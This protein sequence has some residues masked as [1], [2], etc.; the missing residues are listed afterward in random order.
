MT[1]KKRIR[2]IAIM[3]TM[4]IVLASL[5]SGVFAEN[6]DDVQQNQSEM[7]TDNKLILLSDIE[8]PELVS[9]SDVI[10]KGHVSRLPEDEEDL[11]SITFQNIDG[12][13]TTYIFS[14]PV[15]Y[16]D[17]EGIIHDKKSVLTEKIDAVAY[18]NKYGY[19]NADNDI[20]VYFP[21]SLSEDTGILLGKDNISI[22]LT[23]VASRKLETKV[24]SSKT[25]S[26][27]DE[28][29]VSLKELAAQTAE[30]I[31]K[32]IQETADDT[33]V[34]EVIDYDSVF[35]VETTLRYQ[36]TLNGFKEDIVI[37]AYDG[38]NE[39]VFNL[40][41]NG[42]R[43]AGED[44]LYYLIEP[45]TS[46]MV[47]NMGE[48]LVYSGG[49]TELSIGYDHRYDVETVTEDEEYL[50]TIIVDK[51]FLL[52]E[53]TQYPVIVDPSFEILSNNNNIMDISVR[54]NGSVI[55]NSTNN[56]VGNHY[57]EK[58][59]MRTFIKFP[60]LLNDPIFQSLAP[61]E[62]GSSYPAVKSIKLLMYSRG[63]SITTGKVT[64]YPYNTSAALD[65]TYSTTSFTTAQYNAAGDWWDIVDVPYYSQQ[66]I[67]FDITPA[68][69]EE[70]E[71]GVVLRNQY[72]GAGSDPAYQ[73]F[74]S[75]KDPTNKPKIVVNWI[76]GVNTAFDSAAS[77]VLNTV[78]NVDISITQYKLYYSFTPAVSGFYTFESSDNGSDDP[79]GALYNSSRV[80]LKQDDDSGGNRNFR[81]IYH[82]DA[83]QKYYFEAGCYGSTMGSYSFTVSKTT[84]LSNLT[85]TAISTATTGG[86]S[87][88]V[89]RQRNYFS[90]TPSSAGAYNIVS[91]GNSGDPYG[92]LYDS[93]GNLLD[94][95]DNGTGNSNFSIIY[96][97]SKGKK[98]YIVAGCTGNNT[99]SY[100]INISS[101]IPAQPTELATSNIT[102][103][104]VKLTWS[105]ASPHHADRWLIQY[106]TSG[107]SWT[108]AGTSTAKNYTVSG[109]SA[110]TSYE[111]RVYSEAGSPAWTGTRSPVSNTASAT[112][113]PAQP[114]NLTVNSYTDNRVHITWETATP[115]GAD[116]WLIQCRKNG[117]AWE[118]RNTS[119]YKG[120][121]ASSLDASATYEFR[122]YGER[123]D[124]AWSGEKSPVSETITVT[125]LPAQPTNVTV[126]SYTDSRVSISWETAT[127]HGADRW[128]IQCRK[129][130][131]A[132]ENRNTS[133]Y[134][135]YVASSLDASATYEFRVYGERGDTAWS[136]EK[137]PVSETIT[138]TTLPAQPKNLTVQRVTD[139]TVYFTWETAD[140]HG[141]QR[142]LIQC[143]KN[144]GAWEN[145]NT[146]TYKG[147]VA[148]SLDAGATYEFRVYGERGDTAW[149]GV[150]SPV[151][152]TIT[153]TTL[154]AQPKNLTVQNVT[155]SS[156]S[157]TWETATQHG[158]DRWL[159]QY[160]QN[161]GSWSNLGYS[162]YKGYEAEGLS[163]NTTYEFRV[164]GESGNTAWSG[165][166]SAVSNTISI[167]TNVFYGVKPYV[168]ENSDHI[169]CQGYAF[170]TRDW[171]NDWYTD[172]DVDFWWNSYNSTEE[173]YERTKEAMERST[174][175]MNTRF[176]GKWTA[177]NSLS[178]LEPLNSNQWIVCMRVGNKLC[179]D[180]KSKA[181]F[182]Q[183]DYHFWYRTNT[184]KWANK[185]GGTDSELLGND[186][187]ET[188][189]SSGWKL[190]D[191]SPFYDSTIRYYRVS[192]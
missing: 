130:G 28:L 152:E 141:A 21:K 85:S 129:N 18:K 188:N 78:Q 71:K 32:Q 157:F 121:V 171:S 110:S 138:V 73:S 192:Q 116:R 140:P 87:I 11:S 114:T 9:R 91:S 107:G 50:L 142:W 45:E 43:L 183:Y 179:T 119:T 150:R 51:E 57:T 56:A 90:F 30:P 155:S 182:W 53:N 126:N 165:T 8:R 137:S 174:G 164:Y 80:M 39:F 44:G 31:K 68:V 96:S 139:S 143:R 52:D 120:Y 168:Q 147:Y 5:P 29:Q 41:T 158:A 117:G 104:S 15:K 176:N 151:S 113:L 159:I 135:G 184:G 128:L 136:G 79:L 72:E 190:Y 16:V 67:E 23:P 105:T 93:S 14:E 19:T 61:Y 115:H 161:G 20:H 66:W 74:A 77:I 58:N 42:L 185:H 169:N 187:P 86:A 108:N 34:K 13:N 89:A 37:D 88:S 75:T 83:D 145:R 62:W 112:T 163:A 7:S 35:G 55:P 156:V 127:P 181:T 133:T 97:L 118:N 175:F 154:P 162:M 191:Q 131:G 36:P 111:F 180:V 17:E 166:R 132:W 173:V 82:L 6:V 144:G 47:V 81:V 63:T 69:A 27:K 177:S 95:N 101:V 103:V 59:D 167:T 26:A 124:T 160:R 172:K 134:K 125:T 92:W 40:K 25:A 76:G 60:G 49:G 123:G 178:S 153:V 109:L 54:V 38:T 189:T 10:E 24:L 65:W 22:E 102:D 122:V 48:L 146:S 2:I 148:S 12:S 98:Y 64:V 186:T 149:S 100:E 106:R 3:L 1:K 46:Q 84:D 94:K 170:F 70:C 99:D 33:A 4:L